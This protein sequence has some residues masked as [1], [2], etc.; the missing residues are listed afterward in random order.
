MPARHEVHEFVYSVSDV[1]KIRTFENWGWGGGCREEFIVLPS[2]DRQS[3][4]TYAQPNLARW[5]LLEDEKQMVSSC[6][7]T[8][9]IESE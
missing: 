3:G 5:M 1:L 4:L 6:A 9:G 2:A 8:L 7:K